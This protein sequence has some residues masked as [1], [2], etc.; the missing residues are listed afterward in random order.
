MTTLKILTWNIWMMPWWVFSSPSNE[1]RARA[2]GEEL[3]KLD[4]DILC[5]I[6]AFDA[7]ARDELREKLGSRYRFRYGP[8]NDSG[9]LFSINGG[10][11]IMSRIPLTV[12]KEIRYRDSKGLESHSLKG[13][14]LLKGEHEGKPFQIIGT[15]LQ[16][17]EKPGD[18]NQP[19]RDKQIA[20]LA[21]QLVHKVADPTVPLFLCG[22]F[23]TQRQDS[24]QPTTES[25]AYLSMLRRLEAVNGPELR[26]TLDDRRAHNDLAN[27]DT[28][29]Q[30]ELDYI[31]LRAPGHVITGAW[32]TLHLTS[33]SWDKTR[34][35]KDLAYRYAVSGEFQL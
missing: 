18:H 22:D 16:G 27:D 1:A 17:E 8:L 30:G 29:R 26:V 34:R 15:H 23:N 31:L 13:A 14:M 25:K 9:P 20:Q 19:T 12:V 32:Q 2:I 24:K 3:A 7:P 4:F 28:G 21:E 11:Y 35:H 33:W 5:L 10:V 6:K